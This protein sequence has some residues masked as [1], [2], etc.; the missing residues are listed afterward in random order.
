LC[1]EGGSADRG[2]V[3]VL[4][5]GADGLPVGVSFGLRGEPKLAT[6][7]WRGGGAGAVGFG[8]AW[9]G[10]SPG[11]VAGK[12]DPVADLR[13]RKRWLTSVV[14]LRVAAVR[15]EGDSLVGGGDPSSLPVGGGDTSAA[16]VFLAQ[17]GGRTR[18]K[19]AELA[20]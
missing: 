1:G 12:G 15:H 11:Q 18:G 20:S 4:G 16:G 2:G 7:V 13:G 5:L 8:G 14:G 19:D 9:L 10:V 17:C 6:D 3:V